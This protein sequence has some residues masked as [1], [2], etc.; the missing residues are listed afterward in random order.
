MQKPQ[1][2]KACAELGWRK[3]SWHIASKTLFLTETDV[4]P[5]HS[6]KWAGQQTMSMCQVQAS[7]QVFTGVAVAYCGQFAQ[8]F[9]DGPNEAY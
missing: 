8:L 9:S 7:T 6:S 3:E 2:V 4:N 1:F 5:K